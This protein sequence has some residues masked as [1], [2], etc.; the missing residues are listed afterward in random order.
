MVVRCVRSRHGTT[1]HTVHD[2]IPSRPTTLSRFL[3]GLCL[4]TPVPCQRVPLLHCELVLG[5]LSPI[6]PLSPLRGRLPCRDTVLT[7]V[8]VVILVSRPSVV[9]PLYPVQFGHLFL[10]S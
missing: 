5:L 3:F 1:R 10:S 7:V 6:G 4:N 9:S 8:Y 2:T